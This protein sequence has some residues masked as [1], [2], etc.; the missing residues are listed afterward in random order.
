MTMAAGGAVN[1]R[2]ERRLTNEARSVAGKCLDSN[3]KLHP[4]RWRVN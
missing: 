4:D 3:H 1:D 2:R